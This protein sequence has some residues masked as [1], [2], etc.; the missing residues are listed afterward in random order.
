MSDKK[1]F[2]AHAA[3]FYYLGEVFYIDIGQPAAPQYFLPP[4]CFSAGT[5]SVSSAF[6]FQELPPF[7][8]LCSLPL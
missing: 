5:D 2:L 1:I 7:L 8:Q 6:P 4:R 3:L